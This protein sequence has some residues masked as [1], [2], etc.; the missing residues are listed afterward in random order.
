[1]DLYIKRKHPWKS[2]QQK[3]L[4]SRKQWNVTTLNEQLFK[5]FYTCNCPFSSSL[6]S[7]TEYNF[8]ISRDTAWNS[9]INT[10]AYIY[11]VSFCQTW[12]KLWIFI[13]STI[14]W[15]TIQTEI[16][17][18][19]LQLSK[20]CDCKVICTFQFRYITCRNVIC[21]SDFVQIIFSRNNWQI[22][23]IS[24]KI[25]VNKHS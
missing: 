24:D 19:V 17:R 12:L 2:Q 5:V 21:C 10:I 8:G 20:F 11:Y 9:I 7:T 15:V 14:Y 13:V 3:I 4:L 1:M 18:C 22:W 25:Y 23:L 16:T 6:H